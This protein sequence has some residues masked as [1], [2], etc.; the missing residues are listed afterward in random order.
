MLAPADSKTV[1][2]AGCSSFR[3]YDLV[4]LYV[5]AYYQLNKVFLYGIVASVGRL[6]CS[7]D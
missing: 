4:V 2:Q 7:L 6:A 5:L 3:A 1:H